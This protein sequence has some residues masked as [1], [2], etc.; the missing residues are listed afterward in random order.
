MKTADLNIQ[1]R[2]RLLKLGDNVHHRLSR[3]AWASENST[4]ATGPKT[5]PDLR[6]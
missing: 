2:G 4:E 6:K 3:P 5:V 1:R